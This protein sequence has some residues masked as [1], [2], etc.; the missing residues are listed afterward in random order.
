MQLQVQSYLNRARI[1]AQRETVLARTEA[2]PVLDRIVRVMQKLNREIEFEM[3]DKAPGAVLA[4][5]Q[6][7]IEEILGNLLENA[8]RFAKSEIRVSFV[9]LEQQDG[10][11][12]A[13]LAIED[14]GPGLE[15]DQIK[16][17]LKRGRRLDES[18]PGSGLV[19][20]L[21]ARSFQSTRGAS[22][23]R[24]APRVDLRASLIFTDCRAKKSETRLIMRRL[25]P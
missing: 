15:P 6:Q 10:R 17:A 7:D 8:A 20:R 11:D 14:D 23:S 19:F 3:D 5:E 12:M 2:R 25:F 18:R 24:A 1:A 21:S 13:E 22:A 16:E 9:E 4:M